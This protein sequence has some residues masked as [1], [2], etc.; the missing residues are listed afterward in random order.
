MRARKLVEME[1]ALTAYKIKTITR[2]SKGK[3]N[4]K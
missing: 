3:L 2:Q 1:K 4:K